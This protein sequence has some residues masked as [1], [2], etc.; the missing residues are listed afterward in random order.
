M[1]E[2]KKVAAVSAV[3]NYLKTEEEVAMMQAMA[4]ETAPAPIAGATM[5]NAWGISGRQDIM[6]N[7]SL[8]LMKAFHGGRCR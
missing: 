1:H 6:Q 7:N 3:V 4:A 5:V 8:M 2:K